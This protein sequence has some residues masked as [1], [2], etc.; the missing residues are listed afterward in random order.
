M[1]AFK[2]LLDALSVFPFESELTEQRL[3]ETLQLVRSLPSFRLAIKHVMKHMREVVA[4]GAGDHDY[5]LAGFF[6]G[7]RY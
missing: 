5:V 6:S 4:L 2:L 3:E 7:A 1:F